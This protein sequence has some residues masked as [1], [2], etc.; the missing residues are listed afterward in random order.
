MSFL[1]LRHIFHNFQTTTDFVTTTHDD[2]RW[3]SRSDD[4]IN[5]IHH[6]LSALNL[7]LQFAVRDDVSTSA[8]DW[9]TL[10]ALVGTKGQPA[11]WMTRLQG[12]ITDG[13]DFG[14]FTNGVVDEIYNVCEFYFVA[15]F[16][17][18]K[19]NSEFTNIVH[20]VDIRLRGR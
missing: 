8:V 1:G 4:L 13:P 16:A 18:K 6:L 17:K 7:W 3:A 5:V 20:L 12:V 14:K 2:E 19:W 11:L 15:S 9:E 10:E